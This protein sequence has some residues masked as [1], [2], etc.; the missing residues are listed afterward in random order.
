M[1][2]KDK[3]S[4]Y[5][6]DEDEF[7]VKKINTSMIENIDDDDEEEEKEEKKEKKVKKEEKD[8]KRK[9]N[10]NR[11]LNF[12][13]NEIETNDIK[14]NNSS[15]NFF[16]EEEKGINNYKSEIS[17][18]IEEEDEKEEKEEKEKNN[19]CY[20]EKKEGKNQKKININNIYEINKKFKYKLD[21][22]VFY[23]KKNQTDINKLR[24]PMNTGE[25]IKFFENENERY[26]NYK[27]KLYDLFEFKPKNRFEYV[28]L[29][30]VMKPNW[31]KNITYSKIFLNLYKSKLNDDNNKDK[32]K[33]KSDISKKSDIHSLSQKNKLDS[34]N[35]KLIGDNN[36]KEDEKNN[37]INKSKKN[38]KGK[39]KPSDIN[40]PLTFE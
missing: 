25:I 28:D 24:K 18:D 22:P 27:V 29:V 4:S 36:K 35:K 7:G 32:E 17:D 15:L 2:K 6:S 40:V 31:A 21:Y 1:K 30:E 11:I 37:N 5:Y 38:K 13:D 16:K 9:N 34:K 12:N 23:L 19:I 33:H 3:D 20:K 14:T 8:S 39:N 26:E 10:E